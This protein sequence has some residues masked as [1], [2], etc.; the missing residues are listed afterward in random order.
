MKAGIQLPCGAGA[1]LPDGKRHTAHLPQTSRQATRKGEGHPSA[2][3]QLITLVSVPAEPFPNHQPVT[4]G[5]YKELCYLPLSFGMACYAA[6][7]K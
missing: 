3:H 7:D 4:L 6:V 1:G 5:A 2:T